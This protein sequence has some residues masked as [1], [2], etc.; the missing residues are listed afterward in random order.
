MKIKSSNVNLNQK[1]KDDS[2][3]GKKLAKEIMIFAGEHSTAVSKA[4]FQA[5]LNKME[6][7]STQD[8]IK[9]IRSFDKN[10][11]I[12]ELICDEIGDDKKSRKDACK[13]VL[14]ALVNKAKELG[15]DTSDFEKQFTDELASQFGFL[16]IYINTDKLD[17]I[18]NA[19]TQSIENRQN[20]T[21]EDL[22][23][24][25]NTPAEEGARQSNN[26][27]ENRLEK[28]YASFGERVDDN[29]KMTTKDKNGNHYNG[30]M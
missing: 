23:T 27:L 15:I 3:V 14:N 13:K 26:V 28:A 22:Q 21:N 17:S 18:L 2:Q 24:I 12:I 25:K 20:L 6:K 7:L 8:L 10:E 11:S 1:N 19:L 4:E 5:K 16:G 29:G 30:Q 9:F